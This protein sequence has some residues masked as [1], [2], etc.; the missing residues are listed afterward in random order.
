MTIA[1][2]RW[3]GRR[4]AKRFCTGGPV[5]IRWFTINVSTRETAELM[6]RV[7]HDIHNVQY[8]PDGGWVSFDV[9][10]ERTVFVTAL[11]GGTAGGRSEWIRV[12]EGAHAWW[13][14]D[15]KLLYFLSARDGFQCLWAQRLAQKQDSPPARTSRYSISMELAA[16]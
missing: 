14:P 7:D 3:T 5:H 11:K 4:M 12:G 13:S 1:G 16:F 2:F 9:P 15:G 6:P 8:S 10:V